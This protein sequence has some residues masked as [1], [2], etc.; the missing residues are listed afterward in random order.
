MTGHREETPK[1]ERQARTIKEL[2]DILDRT[3][4]DMRMARREAETY[5]E[6]FFEMCDGY[7]LLLEKNHQLA[8]ENLRLK[9]EK[10]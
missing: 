4:V 8:E 6:L 7:Q 3:I 5:Q 2:H 10:E 9:R 1:E